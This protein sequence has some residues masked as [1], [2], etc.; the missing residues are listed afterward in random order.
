[1]LASLL[2]V[3]ASGAFAATTGTLEVKGTVAPTACAITFGGAT[4]GEVDFGAIADRN[5]ITPQSTTMEILCPVAPA[6]NSFVVTDL[7]AVTKSNTAP[8]DAY[9]LGMTDNAKTG[10]FQLTLDSVTRDAQPGRFIFKAQAGDP[11]GILQHTNLTPGASVYAVADASTVEPATASSTVL[12]LT[13]APKID[14]ATSSENGIE[15]DGLVSVTI[16]QI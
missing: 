3:S 6:K 2:M 11:W 1:M 16:T 5:N 8:F 13:L 10:Y 7:K 14:A 15:F 9:G 12:N 4:N